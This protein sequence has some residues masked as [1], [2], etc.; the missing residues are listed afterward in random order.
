MLVWLHKIWIV[1]TIQVLENLFV[2]SNLRWYSILRCFGHL[3]GGKVVQEERV[4]INY[5]KLWKLLIDKEISK[6]ELRAT[7]KIAPSTFHK[8]SNNECI[9]EYA[10]TNMQSTT[11]WAWWYSR[12]GNLKH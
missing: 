12:N 8:M 11:V 3:H 9:T 1:D 10:C 6:A 7:T 4:K 2:I 5:K